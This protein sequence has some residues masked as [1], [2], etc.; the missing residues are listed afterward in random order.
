MDHNKIVENLRN[1]TTRDLDNMI[2][3]AKKL[4]HQCEILKVDADSENIFRADYDKLIDYV[5]R[6]SVIANAILINIAHA[7]RHI[8]YMLGEEEFRKRFG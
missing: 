6:L 7:K 3:I 2:N 5:E 4:I 8:I 1:I